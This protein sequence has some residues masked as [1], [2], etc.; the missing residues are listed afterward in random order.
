MRF[1][2]RK[3]ENVTRREFLH[4]CKEPVIACHEAAF[5][6]REFSRELREGFPAP[7]FAHGQESQK[8][9]ED[10]ADEEQDFR[11]TVGQP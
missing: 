7:A 6:F 10:A 11:M 4:E 3:R 9:L 2:P 8:H 1:S 5:A